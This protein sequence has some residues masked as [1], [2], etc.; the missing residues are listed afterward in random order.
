MD[1]DLHMGMGMGM[2]GMPGM[3]GMGAPE[4]NGESPVPA[5][6]PMMKTSGRMTMQF[7]VKAGQFLSINGNM[8]VETSMG[9]MGKIKANTTFKMNAAR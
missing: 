9:G 3:P 7:N 5:G 2:P 6:A 8:G 4:G 1:L